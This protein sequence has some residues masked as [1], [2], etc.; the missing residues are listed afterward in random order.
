MTYTHS[1]RLPWTRDQLIAEDS[2]WKHTTFPIPIPI[3]C[4]WWDSNLQFQQASS[5]RPTLSN[6]WPLGSLFYFL[7]SCCVNCTEGS[8][9]TPTVLYSTCATRLSVRFVSL[10]RLD[11]ITLIIDIWWKIKWCKSYLCSTVKFPTNSFPLS[12]KYCSQHPLP[13]DA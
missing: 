5:R 6:A 13:S 3:P 4:P 2:T 10:I 9:N 8:A 12:P 7:I 1:V 11:L